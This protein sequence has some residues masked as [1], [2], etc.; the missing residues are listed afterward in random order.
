[1]NL[2][3]QETNKTDSTVKTQTNRE[4]EREKKNNGQKETLASA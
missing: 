1:M 4:R 2:H 3:S